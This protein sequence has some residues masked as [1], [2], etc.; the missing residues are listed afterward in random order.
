M[1]VHLSPFLQK[2]SPDLSHATHGSRATA[3]ILREAVE[4]D[5]G[6]KTSGA[7]LPG[8]ESQLLL[9]QLCDFG[10]LLKLSVPQFPQL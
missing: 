9:E 4:N 8:L 7:S 3:V 5:V 2:L 6:N 1:T 10:K